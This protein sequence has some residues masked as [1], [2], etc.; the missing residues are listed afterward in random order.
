MRVKACLSTVGYIVKTII[1][2]QRKYPSP[3]NSDMGI[4]QLL[5]SKLSSCELSDNPLISGVIRMV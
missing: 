1:W 4:S 3:E 5:Y 2:R